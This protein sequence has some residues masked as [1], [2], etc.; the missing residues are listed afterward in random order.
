M[1]KTQTETTSGTAI[2][3][4]QLLNVIASTLPSLVYAE[5][6]VLRQQR[7]PHLFFVNSECGAGVGTVGSAFER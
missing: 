7:L 1:I 3:Q 2:K 4:F 6:A 5:K